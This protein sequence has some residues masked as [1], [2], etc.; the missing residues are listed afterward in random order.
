MCI[1][2]PICK[3]YKDRFGL[4]LKKVKKVNPILY[5]DFS[6]FLVEHLERLENIFK[7]FN[8]NWNW[9]LRK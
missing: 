3:D 5:K 6:Q 7:F 4:R 8:A 9:K 1:L 2:S